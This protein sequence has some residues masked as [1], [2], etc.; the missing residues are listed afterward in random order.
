VPDEAL[1]T[2]KVQERST[3]PVSSVTVPLPVEVTSLEK[4]TVTGMDSPTV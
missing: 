4:L 2:V 1:A 3:V